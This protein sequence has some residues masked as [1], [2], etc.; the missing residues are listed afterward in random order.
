MNRKEHFLGSEQSAYASNVTDENNSQ[1]FVDN[2]NENDYCLPVGGEKK[3][4]CS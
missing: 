4:V 2:E 1:Y 3:T